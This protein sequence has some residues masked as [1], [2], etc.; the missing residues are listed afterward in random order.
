VE[1]PKQGEPINELEIGKVRDENYGF[2]EM[3]LKDD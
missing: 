1:I 3:E 2:T